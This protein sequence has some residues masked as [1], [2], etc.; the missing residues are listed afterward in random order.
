MG[1]GEMGM[2]P[3]DT[4]PLQSRRNLTSHARTLK[5]FIIYAKFV[6]VR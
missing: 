5:Y 1:L 2:N 4:T 3:L 6:I